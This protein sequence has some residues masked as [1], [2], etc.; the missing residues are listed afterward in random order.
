MNA[1]EWWKAYGNMLG[2]WQAADGMAIICRAS[3][4]WAMWGHFPSDPF[5]KTC[6]LCGKD[7]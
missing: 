2:D 1:D 4:H 5:I 3:A 6:L 7:W